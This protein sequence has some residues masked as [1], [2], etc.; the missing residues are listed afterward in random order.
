MLASVG[1]AWARSTMESIGEVRVVPLV[2]APVA[3]LRKV[4]R[5]ELADEVGDCNEGLGWEEGLLLLLLLALRLL[6]VVESAM[7]DGGAVEPLMALGRR[8]G[9]AMDVVRMGTAAGGKPALPRL[10]YVLWRLLLLRR[11]GLIVLL[12]E[13]A[14]VVVVEEE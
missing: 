4:A 9:A 10:R 6:V 1:S 3:L 7:C 13:A 5:P 14:W 8:A 11:V 2:R 12:A